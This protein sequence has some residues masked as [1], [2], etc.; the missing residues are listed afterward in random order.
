MAEYTSLTLDKF[1]VP[2]SGYSYPN[3]SGIL[4]PKVKWHFRVFVTNFGVGS[5]SQGMDLTQ[6][7]VSVG[8]PKY[9]N[10]EYTVMSYNNISY[11][12][13]RT[14][15]EPINLVVR[16]DVTNAASRLIGAQLMRQ[17]NVFES[18]A[19]PAGVN[20]KFLMFIQ[21]M[22]GGN[23]AILESWM[24]EGAWLSSVDYGDYDYTQSSEYNTI[25]MT[26][27]FDNAVLLGGIMPTAP[28]VANYGAR[29]S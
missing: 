8:R 14:T 3:R 5:P 2:T 21:G 29:L 20:Y 13:G 17:Q 16:D 18:T 9:S 12:A 23:D 27:R 26:V 11:G 6:Q 24:I 15:F 10:P 28:T 7:V 19:F 22:D 4:T 1:G 25:N